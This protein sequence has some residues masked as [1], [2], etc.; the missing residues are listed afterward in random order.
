MKATLAFAV[1]LTALVITPAMVF[2]ESTGPT[3]AITAPEPG[4]TVTSDSLDIGV[5]YAAPDKLEVTRVALLVDGVRIGAAD[6]DPPQVSGATSFSWQTSDYHDGRHEITARAVDSKGRVSAHTITVLLQRGLP[7]LAT[8]LQITT[9]KSGQTVAGTSEIRLDGDPQ[10]VVKYVIFLVD[11]VFKAMTNVRPFGYRWD[12]A[13]YLN[14]LH[15]LQARAYLD[16]GSDYL[17]AAVE[18]N[19]DNPSGATTIRQSEAQPVV[20][21]APA[22]SAAPP[23][24]AETP[25]LPPPMHTESDTPEL[26]LVEV[27]DPEV[28][29]P[30]TAPF[31][32]ASGD[33]IQPPSTGAA[34]RS[35]EGAAVEIAALPSEVAD[36]RTQPIAASTA[37]LDVPVPPA[38]EQPVGQ[39][40]GTAAEASPA[41]EAEPEAPPVEVAALP[42]PEPTPPMPI[43]ASV[44]PM[45]VSVT[46]EATLLGPVTSEAT[47]AEVAALPSPMAKSVPAL[48]APASVAAVTTRAAMVTQRAA[49]PAHSPAATPVEVAMLPPLP[50]AAAPAP[51]VVAEPMPQTTVYLVRAGDCLWDI[52]EKL[53]VSPRQ[54]AEANG[55]SDPRV[56]H[57]GQ[58]LRAP[59]VQLFANGTPVI[60]DTPVTVSKGQTIAPFR[61]IVEHFGGKVAWDS[62]TRSA[63]GSARGRTIAVTI[64]SDQA[65]VDGGAVTM[66]APAELRS[67]RTVVPLRFLG[68]ALSLTLRCQGTVVNIASAE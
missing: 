23:A 52:A 9:P 67:D 5:E 59:T 46:V 63:T 30:G 17:T 51:K 39:P 45:P 38:A 60:T 20:P 48:P 53:G 26:R 14:G 34:D 27:A 33:L 66:G 50:P 25:S 43:E 19:V 7:D 11:N 15:R 1:L 31:V 13:R 24:R 36:E 42:A 29:R 22:P 58:Q 10:Q 12:S 28:A 35:A 65:K 56:I 49:A 21:A 54:L 16:D 40:M 68:K 4:I 57:P 8:A 18:V 61:A 62:G 32:S 2:A 55:I 37:T 44:P 3:I 47:P 6:F 41:I 64:G